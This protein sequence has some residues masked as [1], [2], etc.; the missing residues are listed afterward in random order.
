MPGP[1]AT[2]RG[3]YAPN[4]TTYYT[5][6]ENGF[7]FANSWWS[8]YYGSVD[9]YARAQYAAHLQALDPAAQA[10]AKAAL[11]DRQV[12]LAQQLGERED[13]HIKATNDSAAL[14]EKA[15]EAG[16]KA[17]TDTKV[18]SIGAA[19]QVKG[20][21]IDAQAEVTKNA[22]MNT[23]QGKALLSQAQTSVR[24]ELSK[25]QAAALAAQGK[26]AG[27]PAVIAY[28]DAVDAL[29]ATIVQQTKALQTTADSDAAKQ[30]AVSDLFQEVRSATISTNGPDGSK[31]ALS[32]IPEEHIGHLRNSI[33]Q[34]GAP[35]GPPRPQEFD[36]YLGAGGGGKVQVPTFGG[37]DYSIDVGGS[38][39]L[40]GSISGSPTDGGASYREQLRQQAEKDL[41]GIGPMF[42][43]AARATGPI[44][45][46]RYED[47]MRTDGKATSEDEDDAALT[48][49]E[50]RRNLDYTR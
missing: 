19:A 16:L 47:V 33:E 32:A 11:L 41:A 35:I 12:K 24:A 15:W 20:H 9:P 5:P 37:T 23:P 44:G 27:D 50:K 21:V 40:G 25:V 28:G 8:G 31:V 34:S 6:T 43:E 2:N 14:Q 30:A 38:R 48:E 13:A 39:S 45:A 36:R 1:I 7:N 4:V 18:A 26:P 42:D 46:A 22:Q 10:Q 3:R 17:E 49:Y 29:E